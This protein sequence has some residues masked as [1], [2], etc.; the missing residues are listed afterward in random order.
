VV[1]VVLLITYRSPV[2]WIVPLLSVGLASQLFMGAVYLLGRYA[3]V[4]VTDAS[5]GIT[6][7]LVFG[8]G[9]DYALLL[10]ARYREELRRHED[11]YTAMVLAWRRSFPAILASAAT[12]TLGLLCLLAAQM[13][14][15]RGLG[16]VAAAGIL[17]A[18]AVVTTLM[19]ALLVLL[20]R[21]VFWPFVPRF[22][23]AHENATKTPLWTRLVGRRPRPIWMLA[24]LALAALGLGVLGLRLGQPADSV[25]T[26]EVGSV[27]GQ[28]LI[29]QHFPRGASSPVRIIAAAGSADRVVAA[30]ES[31]DGVAAVKPV[32]DSGDSQWVPIEAVLDD[33][34]DSAAANA[35]V[36]RIRETV[37]AVPGADALVGGE[38]AIAIDIERAASRDNALLM[39]AIL[40]VVF[41]VL[42]ILLRAVVAPLLLAASVML[43]YVAAMGLAGLVLSVIGY[44]AMPPT[45]PLWGYIFLVTLGVDYTIFLMTRA[46][47]E[48]ARAGNREG[49]L[50]ALA[51]TGGVI[52][53][54]GI[55][56]AA[57]F[58]TLIVLPVVMA[59]QIGLIVALGV[60]LDTFV[61][62]TL[63]VPA[64]AIDLGPRIWWPG[65]IGGAPAAPHP[66]RKRVKLAV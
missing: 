22:N 65:R 15:V 11:R 28:R 52:T 34:P 33:P 41:A 12:V 35:T 59:L 4:T 40:L 10:I 45:L 61:V 2:L 8:A 51:V 37:H 55:V 30:A 7:V 44:P 50:S 23:P 38:T 16:P 24:T 31:V 49:I 14:D 53:S 46:R 13:N 42:I 66:D 32:V 29:A 62:R 5:S 47:E 64:L 19:P 63:L 48:V 58:G 60:L 21:W 1:A 57:T 6:L 18:F 39:P 26:T 9:T 54:A 36:D 43:S 27:A 56:L 3:G 25:Y 17:M 20:G